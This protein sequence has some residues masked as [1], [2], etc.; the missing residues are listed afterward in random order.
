[1]FLE[2][3]KQTE[4]NAEACLLLNCF[5]RCLCAKSLVA[6]LVAYFFTSKRKLYL[7]QPSQLAT[8][9][10]FSRSDFSRFIRS[11]NEQAVA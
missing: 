11:I 8:L 4:L 5:D 2:F 3:T 7:T 6:R 10:I 1:M 9:A